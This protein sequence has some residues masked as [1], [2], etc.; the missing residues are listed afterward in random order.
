[1]PTTIDAI[2]RNIYESNSDKSVQ[3]TTIAALN[4]VTQINNIRSKEA[5]TLVNPAECLMLGADHYVLARQDD[6]AITPHLTRL[7]SGTDN[8]NDNW[9]S[10]RNLLHQLTSLKRAW[11]F[12]ESIVST[13]FDYYLFARPD[14]LYLDEIRFLQIAEKFRGSGNIALPAWHHWGGGLNDR[15]A[16]TD[17]LAAEHYANRLDLLDEFNAQNGLS[18]ERLLGYAVGKGDCR[19]SELPVR[20]QRVR[21]DGAIRDENFELKR[22]NLPHDGSRILFTPEGVTIIPE[23]RVAPVPFYNSRGIPASISRNQLVGQ[24]TPATG[25][26]THQLRKMEHEGLPRVSGLSG[27]PTEAVIQRLGAGSNTRRFLNIGPNRVTLNIQQE[28]PTPNREPSS[29]NVQ[30]YDI[31]ADEFFA[32][33]DPCEVLAGCIDLAHIKAQNHSEFVLRMIINI[34]Q[35]CSSNSKIIFTDVVPINFEMTERARNM[36]ARKDQTLARACTGDLWRLVPLL[37]RERPD[38]CIQVANCRPTGL[39]VISNLDPSSRKL[40]DDYIKTAHRLMFNH[41][42]EDEFWAYIETLELFEATQVC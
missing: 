24:Q 26:E 14:L 16:F 6:S 5:S 19:I 10:I 9:A 7:Q 17:G 40:R 8:F 2:R 28:T 31:S 38:L 15:F 27:P 34:E 1:M 41:P 11:T 4:L 20:A 35:Y 30:S 22:R 3:I 23:A 18:P 42:S 36:R 39:V 25:S 32:T 37:R 12:C 33:T 21:A 13:R 29:P